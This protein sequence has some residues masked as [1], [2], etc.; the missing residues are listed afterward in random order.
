VLRD[1][2]VIEFFTNEMVLA[3]INGEKDSLLKAQYHISAFPTLVMLDTKGAEVDRIVGYRD[4][5][6]F[7]Q[8]LSDYRKGIGTLAD[9]LNKVET[10]PDRSLS[11]EIAE[12]Y[13]YRGGGKEAAVWYQKV[14]DTGDP[15][16]SLSGESRMALADMYRRAKDYDKALDAYGSIMD[17]FQGI[18]FAQDAELWLGVVYKQKGDTV[19]AIEAYE[20]FIKHYPESEDVEWVQ[21]QIK[22]LK[23]EPEEEKK[24]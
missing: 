7:L 23:G 15:A 3:K 1:S 8:T 2:K 20:N 5:D 12:K 22:K 10:N 16:D 17:D 19:H 14:I 24:E 11:F 6:E 21:K 9:L 4:P 18:P 13:K